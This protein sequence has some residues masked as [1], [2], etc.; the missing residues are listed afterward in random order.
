MFWGQLSESVSVYH[1][2]EIKKSKN[3][4]QRSCDKNVSS[5]AL[6]SPISTLQPNP[7][8]VCGSVKSSQSQAQ[9]LLRQQ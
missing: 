3:I 6:S 8:E 1:G 5:C 4:L 2:L 9:A 7:W